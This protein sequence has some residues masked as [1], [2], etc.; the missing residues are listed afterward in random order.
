MAERPAPVATHLDAAAGE[1]EHL[2]G[3]LRGDAADHAE[4]QRRRRRDEARHLRARISGTAA[5]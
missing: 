4:R 2:R 1:H 3:D 5:R